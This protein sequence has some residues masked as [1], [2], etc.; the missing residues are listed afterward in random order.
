MKIG[1]FILDQGS[2]RLV[3]GAEIQLLE[4][5]DFQILEHLAEEAPN[6]VSSQILID[7]H[8][9]GAEVTDNALH[10]AIARLRKALGDDAKNPRYIETL[11]RRGYRLLAEVALQPRP[12]WKKVVVGVAVFVFAVTASVLMIP[13]LYSNPDQIDD[14]T[15]A[16]RATALSH[17]HPASEDYADPNAFSRI[18]TNL[19]YYSATRVSDSIEQLER[20]IRNGNIGA[21]QHAILAKLYLRRGFT[22]WQTRYDDVVQAELH[23]RHASTL[24]PNDSLVLLVAG[25]VALDARGDLTEARRLYEQALK[26]SPNSAITLESYAHVLGLMGFSEAAL[27]A[28]ERAFASEPLSPLI[29]R[30]LGRYLLNNGRTHEAIKYLQRAIAIN[31]EDPPAPGIL[32]VAHHELGQETQAAEAILLLVAPTKRPYVRALVQI[33]G[34]AKVQRWLLTFRQWQTDSECTRQPDLVLSLIHI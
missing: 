31:P 5:R 23:E 21:Q 18:L 10:Q 17:D 6:F 12:T 7:R 22:N 13:F 2:Q 11:P 24:E 32:W 27:A 9:R 8:W 30:Q 4:A 16:Q 1:E 34:E 29:N 28:I 3:N 19:H 15:V 33:F 25:N 14:L 26:L 20:L